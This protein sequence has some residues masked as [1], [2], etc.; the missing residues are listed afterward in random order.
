MAIAPLGPLLPTIELTSGFLALGLG[1]GVVTTIAG[2]G[3]GLLLLLA[4]SAIV[5]PHA[6]L[7]ITA[8]ALLF[9]NLHRSVL[10]RTQVDR[11]VAGRMILGAVPGALAGG[12]LAGVMPAWGLRSLLVVTTALAVAKAIGLIRFRVPAAALTPAGAVVGVLTGTAGGAG[13]LFAP[14]LLS[15]GLS[16][17]TFVATT[18]TIAFATHVGRVAGYASLG[19]FSLSLI[20]P[21]VAVTLAIFVGNALGDRLRSALDGATEKTRLTTTLEYGTLVVCVA[22]SVA[23]L[24]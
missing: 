5:G 2:Q 12:L 6:A 16:G 21:T 9:G 14:V 23:G 20:A 17:R 18:S 24:G 11:R 4:C 22:L 13:V 7:A 19:L 10:L 3:G 1:A 15:S 8:P